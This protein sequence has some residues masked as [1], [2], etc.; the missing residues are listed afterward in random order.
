VTLGGLVDGANTLYL[1][2]P[3]HDQE[4]LAPVFGG[5]IGDLLAQ[6]YTRVG[7]T[8][9]PLTPLLVVLDEAGN[10]PTRWLPQVAST[11]AGIG[12]VLVTVWQSKS[13]IDAAYGPLA[14][15][16]LTNHLTKIV[17]AGVSDP[18]TGDYVAR[19]LGDEDVPHRTI[20]HHP[21]G[22]G[23][24]VGEDSREHAL[25]PAHALRRLRP[26]HALL[27]HGTLPPAHLRSIPYYRDRRL[28]ARATPPGGTP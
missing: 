23:F 13:Q 8:G 24:Q 15:T 9:R 25:L 1:C 22:G 5:L 6:A 21:H 16:V 12:I 17:Y 26:G 18:A 11:C 4:R 7:R 19:L 2:A 28:A 10:T 3:L 14:D 20:S 27:V